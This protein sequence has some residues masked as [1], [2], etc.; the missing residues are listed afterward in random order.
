ML[1]SWI[2]RV[3]LAKTDRNFPL[4]PITG[5]I[6]EPINR[7]EGACESVKRLP[8]MRMHENVDD[9][10]VMFEN[11]EGEVGFLEAYAVVKKGVFC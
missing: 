3:F 6:T 4:S 5:S 11:G 2:H 7:G 10:V 9:V 8:T 1:L